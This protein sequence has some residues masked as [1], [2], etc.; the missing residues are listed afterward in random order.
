MSSDHYSALAQVAAALSSPTRLRALNLLFQGPKSIDRVAE[1]LGESHANTAAHL[2]V[3]RAAGL[4]QARR[5]GKHIFQEAVEPDALRLFM[6]LRQTAELH[7]AESRLQSVA[8][9]SSASA[10]APTELKA[11]IEARKAIVYDLR[12][13]DEFAAGHI[14]GARSLPLAQLSERVASL[15]ATKQRVLAYCRGKYCPSAIQ[16]TVLL[17]DAGL[18]AECLAF[19][20]PEW[21]ALGLPI[22]VADAA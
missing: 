2:K 8:L 20:V 4:V 14:P 19:G 1:L 13:D 7:H 22:E 17:C 12:P 11:L 9:E 5:L 10:L 15:R 21:R 16:G 3:L 6:Q 18:R